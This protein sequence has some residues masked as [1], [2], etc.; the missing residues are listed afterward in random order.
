VS[1][2]DF[3]DFGPPDCYACGWPGC[4]G[5][6]MCRECGDGP[7]AHD[8]SCPKVVEHDRFGRPECISRRFLAVTKA[9]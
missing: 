3:E 1:W 6:C 2:P 5:S 4:S 8:P 7:N 9:D